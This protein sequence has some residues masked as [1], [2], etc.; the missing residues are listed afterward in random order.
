M[1]DNKL[2]NQ[3]KE[4]VNNLKECFYKTYMYKMCIRIL[5]WLAN[6]NREY[7]SEVRR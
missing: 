2:R 5:D 1:V 6:K 3:Y 7:I 4:A